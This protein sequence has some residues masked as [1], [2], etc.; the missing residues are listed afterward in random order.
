M[1][2]REY[3]ATTNYYGNDYITLLRMNDYFK[4]LSN[5]NN[6]YMYF[7]PDDNIEHVT[8]SEDT[9]VLSINP[10]MDFPKVRKQIQENYNDFIPYNQDTQDQLE[11]TPY[12]DKIDVSSLDKIHDNVKMIYAHAVGKLHPKIQMIPIGRDFKNEVIFRYVDQLTKTNKKILCY[13][14]VTLPPMNYHWYGFVRKHIY[15]IVRRKHFVHCKKCDMHPRRYSQDD[16]FTYYNDLATSKFSICPRGAGIDTYRMWDSI[17]MGCIPI[18]E[19]YEGYQQFEDLPILYVDHWKDID[20]LTPEILEAKW[21]EMMDT[22]YNYDKL[23]M[24]YWMRK[25]GSEF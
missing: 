25:I 17:T 5:A 16:V 4:D 19:K 12:F 1:K 23:R 7:T 6:R 10:D 2:L 14:N 13:Y 15:E 8:V 3:L 21:T 9:V 11:A 22:E 18:V 20:E 24:S